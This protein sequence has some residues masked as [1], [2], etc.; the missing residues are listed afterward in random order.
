M[1][2]KFKP[3]LIL[4]LAAA[5]A[6]PV[7]SADAGDHG[8]RRASHAKKKK[9]RT[10]AR[11][12][13]KT[14][15]D[16]DGDGIPNRRD[17]DIDGDRIPNRRDRNTDGDR[18]PNR[19]DRDVDGDRIPNGRD[20]E[21]DGDFLRNTR[22][23]DMDG[24]GI[25]NSG[26]RD[27]DGDGIPNV[28]DRDVD[29]DGKPNARDADIDGDRS[30][31]DFDPDIDGDGV[32]NFADDDSDC[33]GSVVSGALPVGVQLPRRFFGVVADDVAAAESGAAR[34][35]TLGPIAQTG[36]RTLR[37]KFDWAEIETS[38][39]E[40]DFSLYDGYVAD[41]MRHGFEVL[42]ILFNPPA[43]RSSDPDADPKDGV[44]PPRRNV[45]F[46]DFATALVRRYGPDGSFWELDPSLPR[47]PLRAW[48]VWNEPNTKHYWP[49]GPKPEQYA[50]MLRVVGAAIKRADP[51]AEVVTAGL[52]ESRIGMPI[53]EFL[54]GMYRAGAKGTFD[55]LAIHPYARA[56]DAVWDIMAKARGV[57][58][59]NGDADVEMRVTE[60]GWATG[61]PAD[62][63]LNIG[64]P[65]QA[66]L[67]RRA[68][69]G[70]VRARERM[71]LRGIV[72]FNWRDQPP[73]AGRADYW[74]LH[75]GL[76][77]VDG[78]P[79]DGYWSFSETVKAL[80]AP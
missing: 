14:R 1:R 12:R 45:E 66:A 80:T 27:M 35:D 11:K 76:L 68:L 19:R 17:R 21:I 53:D 46:A 56:A 61:G 15:R 32:P 38:P 22:D 33:S 54:T 67:T 79:K 70:L 51:G 26:D 34:R 44:Y 5:L 43:F 74:G 52:P 24:D 64:E 60:L 29:G 42:P 40:Y 6:A 65:G 57:M 30:P 63:P 59:R 36:A 20:R 75:A 31:N 62:Q 25:P 41:A 16:L 77:T 58:D 13:H 37:Q 73:Y 8:K 71:K 49:T 72:Y 48:Q 10:H 69:A 78:A 9:Q 3:L 18:L 23:G 47:R 55:T 28:R 7:P 2:V 39:G 50:G 4:V